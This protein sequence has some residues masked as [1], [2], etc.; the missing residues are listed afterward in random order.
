[1]DRRVALITGGARGMGAATAVRLAATGWRLVLVDGGREVP[2]VG[3]TLAR[4]AELDEVVERCG[5]SPVAVGVYGDVRSQLDLDRAVEVAVERYGGL[6]AA[7][8]VAGYMAGGSEAWRTPDEVWAT[9][10]AINLEGVWRLA[11]AAIPALLERPEPRDGRFVAVA[12]AGGTLG[13]PLLSA[14]AAAKHG[15]VGLIRSLAA[16]LGPSGITANAVAP[17]STRTAMLEAAANVYGLLDVE[18]FAIHHPL[19][20]LIE[21]DEVAA[22]LAWLCGPESGAL[23]GALLAVDAG[24]TAA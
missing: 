19:G 5:G 4:P 13:L 20:R 1:V 3:Y 6:D 2:D 17:G 16:E 21:P 10:L 11:R 14:Y 7:I 15:V 12:S 18:G 23:T 24:M 22:L 8:A 9:V